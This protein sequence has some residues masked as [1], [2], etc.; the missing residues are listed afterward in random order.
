MLS[1]PVARRGPR[2]PRRRTCPV[3]VKVEGANIEVVDAVAYRDPLTEMEHITVVGRGR[4]PRSGDDVIARF[5][6]NTPE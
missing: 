4:K 3:T 6:G 2:N 1:L 5:N